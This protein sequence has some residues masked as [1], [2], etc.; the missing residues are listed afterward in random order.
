MS[1]KF[2]VRSAYSYDRDL[3]SEGTAFFD[4]SES[5]TQQS[6]KEECDIN[7]IVRRFGVTGEMPENVRVP[8]YAD[9][10]ESFDF[11]SAMNLIRE[12]QESFMA[13]PSA[14]RDRFGHDPARFVD[15]FNDPE[16]R[17]EAERLGVLTRR[18]VPSQPEPSSDAPAPVS[19][20][21]GPILQA[22]SAA[23]STSTT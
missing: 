20:P 10:E 5:M 4:D 23:P 2:V 3:N 21:S 18:P 22:A 8:Q 7:T 11:M 15:F 19:G 6:F 17:P 12:A 16:N 13:M 14:V 9:F 1:D